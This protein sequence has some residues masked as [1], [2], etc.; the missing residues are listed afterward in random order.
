MAR[1]PK[2]QVH[3]DAEQSKP[4]ERGKRKPRQ[5]RFELVDH[6]GG[7][8]AVEL[9]LTHKLSAKDA[10]TYLNSLAKRFKW[11][12]TFRFTEVILYQ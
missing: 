9:I 4:K 8:E 10:L 5:Y 1:Q 11:D 7:V 6:D 3:A 2:S 12:E